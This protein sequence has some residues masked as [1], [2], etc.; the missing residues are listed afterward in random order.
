MQLLRCK[1]SLKLSVEVYNL[2]NYKLKKT[3]SVYEIVIFNLYSTINNKTKL[4]SKLRIY[5]KWG[6]T[7]PSN[8]AESCG[9]RYVCKKLCPIYHL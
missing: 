3:V 4:N 8:Y 6:I 5:E 1:T 9:V 2:I 7:V